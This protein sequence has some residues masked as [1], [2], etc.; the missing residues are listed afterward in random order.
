MNHYYSNNHSINNSFEVLL[1]AN[2]IL[3]S[4][5]TTLSALSNLSS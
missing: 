5:L 2:Y 3:D 1:S 4:L